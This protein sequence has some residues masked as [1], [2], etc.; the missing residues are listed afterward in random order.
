[1]APRRQAPTRG[2][3]LC[4]WGVVVVSAFMILV[5]AT[6]IVSQWHGGPTPRI[7]PWG[8][9]LGMSIFLIWGVVDIRRYHRS[10]SRPE[11]SP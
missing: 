2:E 6:V 5:A 7:I 11:E 1:M 10:T 9:A 4:A 8:T 3:Y